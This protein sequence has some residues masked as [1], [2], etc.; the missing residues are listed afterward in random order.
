MLLMEKTVINKNTKY[1]IALGVG[2]WKEVQR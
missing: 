2:Y 1:N